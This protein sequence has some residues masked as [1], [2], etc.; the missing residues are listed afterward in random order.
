VAVLLKAGLANPRQSSR[1]QHNNR[2]VCFFGAPFS[3]GLEN[4]ALRCAELATE[5]WR[6][7]GGVCSRWKGVLDGLSLT[8][9]A[10][11]TSGYVT[12]GNFGSERRLEYTAVGRAITEAFALLRTAKAADVVCS[13]ITWTLINQHRVGQYCGELVSHSSSSPLKMYR[14]M[15]LGG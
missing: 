11:L 14:L 12:A 6:R 9:T 7:I 4:D 5:L 10:A 1:T 2:V 13:P 8:P 15:D 3:S